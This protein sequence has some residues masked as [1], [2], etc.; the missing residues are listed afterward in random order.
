[1]KQF[2]LLISLQLLSIT[3]LAQRYD[4]QGKVINK[5]DASPLI[6]AHV[7]LQS[8]SS[9][10]KITVTD[11][12]GFFVLGDLEKGVYQLKITHLGYMDYDKEISVLEHFDL[13]SIRM[14]EG[15]RLKGVEITEKVIPIEQQGDTMQFNAKAYKTLPDASAEELIEKMPTINVDGGKVEAQGEEVKQVLVDGKAFFGNDPTAAL[16]NLPAEVIDKIQVFDQQSDQSQF[17]GFDDGNT[18]KTI[19]IITNPNMRNGQFGKVYG[20]YG[21]DNKYQAG[22]NVNVFNGDQ[23]IS[24]IGQ[25]N[26]INKQNFAKE[27]LLGVLGSNNSR[28]GGR[29]GRGGR[30]G[31][32]GG[33][34]QSQ[35]SSVNDFLVPQ[36]GGV[37]TTHAFGLNYTDKWGEQLDVEASYFFNYT[38]N[39]SEESLIQNFVDNEEVQESYLEESNTTNL[40]QNH[41]LNARLTYEL[42]DKN[43][44]I[45]RPRLSWQGN[46]GL[47]NTLGEN[48]IGD[49]LSSQTTNIYEANLTALNF[50]NNLLWRHKFEKRRRT[51][52]INFSNGFAPKSGS[53][54]LFSQNEFFRNNTLT[55]T[56]DQQSILDLNNLTLGTNIQYT[57]PIGRM[58][59]LM[60]NY[61]LSYQ[62]EESDQSVFD[63][64]TD[65][66]DYDSFNENL[67]N[68]F[69][70]DYQTHQVGGGYNY[71]KRKLM[72]MLRANVQY[73]TLVNEQAFPFEQTV[74]NDF[75]NILP[76]AVLRIGDRKTKNLSIFYRTNTQL[77]SINQL[78]NV[79]DNSNPIQ[80][81][82]G[83]PNLLQSFQHRLF[84][85]YSKTNVEKSSVFFVLLSGAYT[86]DYIANSLYLSGSD[87][88]IF[89]EL[90]IE[91]EA[92]LS[93]P[94]NLDGYWNTR[95]LMT[96]GFPV[97]KLSSNLNID[98]S[99]NYNTIPGLINEELNTSSTATFGLGL[100]LG[101]NISENL[102]FTIASRSSYNSTQNSLQ[103]QANTNFLNQKTRLK[104]NWIIAD[105]WIFRTD[106]THQYYDG[107]AED[108]DTNFL[109]WNASIGKKLFENDRG[110]ISIS[111]FDILKQNVNITRNITEVYIEDLQTNALQQFFMLNFKYDIRHFK[112]K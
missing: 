21:Y 26:N 5:S 17:T 52:S 66:N 95:A 70:N 56:L 47:S 74:S 6:G 42:N 40:N 85:R 20:G 63:F 4:L 73:A 29:G 59:M 13:G 67:S 105:G 61:R 50:S 35:G 96:Y 109:L 92:Q 75:L 25:S 11:L 82:T 41:R 104:F 83:N 93:L 98:L 27:D 49:R 110:E 23:R 88:P 38:D 72:I 79:L 77:P 9:G 60:F 36:Q 43:S 2:T 16:R 69:A 84:A 87:A 44:L 57:E 99:V 76:M 24:I 7:Y 81:S 30:R 103:L 37:A 46:D 55:D 14:V 32:G 12:E 8:E 71:R 31:R 58:A 94:V 19:N 102:D 90:G 97:E 54:G 45:L 80:L 108:L 53:N 86:N 1:M 48:L 34:G 100:T 18:S 68:I 91:N 10:Q 51:L 3:L 101:S 64:S 89:D 106:L 111:A 15:T 62:E 33:R 39:L 78:Q 28:R 22:G 65:T 107:L 112:V